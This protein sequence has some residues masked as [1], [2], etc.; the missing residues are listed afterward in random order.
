M[1]KSRAERERETLCTALLLG[2][3]RAVAAVV[4]AV[5]LPACRNAATRV[6]T[7]ELVHTTRH[8][9]CR[10]RHEEKVDHAKV[11]KHIT[12]IRQTKQYDSCAKHWLY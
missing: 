3:I 1:S 4:L 12:M 8:L 2:F 10:R 9:S 7:A 6:L 11:I 5:T